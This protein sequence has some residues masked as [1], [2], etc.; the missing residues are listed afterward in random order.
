MALSSVAVGR[1]AGA[2]VG[3]ALGAAMTKNQKVEVG[4]ARPGK[5]SERPSAIRPSQER[6]PAKPRA[7][8]T[9]SRGTDLQPS[10]APR[11]AAER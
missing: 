2:V 11:A 8:E 6:A 3:L 4:T 9:G 10:P 7:R 1:P 5:A